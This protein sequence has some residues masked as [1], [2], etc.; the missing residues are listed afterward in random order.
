MR[1]FIVTRSGVA[2]VMRTYALGPGGR[3]VTPNSTGILSIGRVAPDAAD[4]ITKWSPE[5]QA[6]VSSIRE[7]AESDIPADATFKNAWRDD[8]TNINI[9]M[10]AARDINAERLCRQYV[11]DLASAKQGEL[12]ERFKGNTQAANEHESRVA[13]L[14]S[15]SINAV[16]AKIKAATTLKALKEITV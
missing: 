13:A 7:I 4:E 9:D 2:R 12:L 1:T 15:V 16:A 3:V 6:A 14:E 5:A 11:L 8:N 10:L